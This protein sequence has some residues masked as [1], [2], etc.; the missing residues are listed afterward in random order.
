[1]VLII[2]CFNVSG[3]VPQGLIQE[4]IRFNTSITN[5]DVG[6]G[7]ILSN[8]QTIQNSRSG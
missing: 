6:T 7:C 1:M 5:P 3:G 4:V 2:T 8:T